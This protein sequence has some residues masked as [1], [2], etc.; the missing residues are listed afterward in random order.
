MHELGAA[1]MDELILRTY[2]WAS[3]WAARRAI[4][5]RSRQRDS[6]LNGRF[7]Q[8]DVQVILKRTRE[9]FNE[10]SR[11]H[12]Q[13]EAGTRRV[14]LLACLTHALFRALL[15]AGVERTYAIELTSDTI[16][17][18]YSR[19]YRLSHFLT[20]GFA[21]LD[22][23]ARMRVS[24]RRAFQ[25]LPSSYEWQPVP[26]KGGLSFEIHRCPAVE[27]FRANGAA[28]LCAGAWCNQDY[29]LAEIWGGR[30]EREGTLAS[31]HDHCDFRFRGAAA[32]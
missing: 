8:S 25:H 16:W 4:T 19:M 26:E 28:D 23:A 9:L 1:N 2:L 21:R 32:P 15:E 5:E 10:F 14:L 6:P 11:P 27:Y 7:T 3:R 17:K 18:L 13:C 30:L 22:R 24:V 31:G 12:F 20:T 29:G